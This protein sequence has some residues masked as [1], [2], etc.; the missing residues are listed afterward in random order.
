MAS[1]IEDLLGGLLGGKG[2]ARAS[3]GATQAGGNQ[4]LKTLGP[5]VRGLLANGG[6]Q[7]IMG[8]MKAKGL[9]AQADSWVAP[10][11][12]APVSGGDVREA[13]GDEEISKIVP[14]QQNLDGLLAGLR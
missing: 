2:A 6:P 1:P 3:S 14:D 4:L 9:G 10:G 7:N 11:Q 8:Q 5:V 12:N 13:L